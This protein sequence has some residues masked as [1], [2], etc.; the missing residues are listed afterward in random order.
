MRACASGVRQTSVWMKSLTGKALKHANYVLLWL[1]ISAVVCECNST[2]ELTMMW[3]HVVLYSILI[4]QRQNCN[5]HNVRC[6]TILRYFFESRCRGDIFIFHDQ[7]PHIAR[8]PL[9]VTFQK[10]KLSYILDSL[11]IKVN[12]FNFFFLILMIRAYSSWKSKI[13][14]L[15]ILEYFLR[16]IKMNLPNRKVQ[17]L[18]ITTHCINQLCIKH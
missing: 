17:V 16:S 5:W 15:K 6:S 2:A 4:Q 12:H 8:T 10:G 9:I 14:Y 7:N 1:R 11:H 13:Q 3:M 18:Y